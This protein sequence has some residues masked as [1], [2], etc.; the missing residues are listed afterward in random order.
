MELSN[1]LFQLAQCYGCKDE[2]D[3]LYERLYCDLLLDKRM[4]ENINQAYAIVVKYRLLMEGSN[5]NPT[6]QALALDV[7]SYSIYRA[8]KPYYSKLNEMK[9]SELSSQLSEKKHIWLSI[10]AQVTDIEK[11]INFKDVNRQST[12]TDSKKSK[13]K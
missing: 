4:A 9:V 8:R 12:E 5:E 2:H 6:W 7:F 13:Q 10:D 11:Y 3:M 1:A